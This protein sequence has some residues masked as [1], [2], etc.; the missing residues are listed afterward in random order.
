[1][2]RAAAA[3]ALALFTLPAAQAAGGQLDSFSA[4]ALQVRVGETVQFTVAYSGSGSIDQNGGSDLN[5]P[6][7]V[8]GWQ[9]WVLNWYDFHYQTVLSVDLRAGGQS[10]VD[11]PSLRAGD[12]HSGSWMFSMQF[13]QAGSFEVSV[14]GELTMLHEI[15]QGAELAARS[16]WNNDVDGGLDLQCD[17]WVYEY[18]QYDDWYTEGLQLGPLSLKV[19][20][21]AVPEPQAWALWLLGAG[22]LG[23]RLRQA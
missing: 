2:S 21:Q 19:Q 9:P 13:D 22:L 18:P 16:C 1:M 14:Q 6:L 10:F 11:A 17:A 20:V 23:A 3:T 8:E 15:S 7:P 12:G 5:E 4:S